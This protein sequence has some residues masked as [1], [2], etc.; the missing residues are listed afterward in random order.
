MAIGVDVSE[1]YVIPPIGWYEYIGPTLI[2]HPERLG[3]CFSPINHE[4]R[5]L[6]ALKTANK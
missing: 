4:R 2:D 5:R 1:N 6:N 3:A